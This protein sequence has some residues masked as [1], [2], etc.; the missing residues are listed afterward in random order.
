MGPERAGFPDHHLF[1]DSM[2]LGRNK[3]KGLPVGMPPYHYG[4]RFHALYQKSPLSMCTFFTTLDH[5]QASH[6][7]WGPWRLRQL[8]GL[9]LL[10]GDSSWRYRWTGE[11]RKLHRWKEQGASLRML[12][13]VG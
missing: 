8:F 10:K 2:G 5:T 11:H 13:V 1:G 12:G 9:F 3:Q 4:L 6:R 7:L